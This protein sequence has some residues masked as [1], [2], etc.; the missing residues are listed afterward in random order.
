M[1]REALVARAGVLLLVAWLLLSIALP[2]WALLSKSFQ[3][4]NGEF[5]WLANYIR[6][7]STPSLF[8]SIFNSIGVA[9]VTTGIVIPL[10]FVYAYAL[11]RS[12]M[13]FKGLFY[14]AAMLPLFAP[15]LLSAISLIYLFGNQGLLKGFMFGSSIY[16]A[17][18]IIIAQ[19]FYC[20]AHALIIAVTELALADASL[21]ELDG[22]LGIRKSA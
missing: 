13:R 21:Y 4:Q 22:A 12:R 20:F 15:S 6:Y 8:N 5:V 3:N 1:S 17:N 18:G 11:T 9:V 2:L 16:G 19:V 10:A 7:F 14:A